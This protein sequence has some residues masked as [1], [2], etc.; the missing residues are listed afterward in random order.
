VSDTDCT[1]LL[2]W[3]L[4]QLELRWPGF[5]KVRRQV[6]KRLKQRM[7][8]LGLDSYAAY[9]AR[10]EA[11]PSEWRILDACCHITIS[12]F[13]RDR[14]I[15]EAV[16]RHVLPDIAARAKREGRDAQVWS[17]GC[18]SGEEPYTLKILW[19]VEI[20][21]EFPSVA[22][23]IVASDIDRAMLA[24]AREGRFEPTSLRELPPQLAE[25]AFDRV[26][27][28][29]CVRPKHREGIEF[30]DQDLRLEMPPRI[31]DLILCRYVAFT[32][33]AGPL[34]RKILMSMLARLRPQGYL[35]I[36]T[37]EH[38]PGE[39]PELAALDSAPQI[40]QKR[41]MLQEA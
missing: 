4:P 36:G 16:R 24:R 11:D 7:R 30:L 2:Q 15:F 13:F 33:F 31:F 32:Y 41:P 12:R 20:A 14:G 38:L 26:G 19:D 39:I 35:V 6:C 34:Q 3:A 28:L 10:L 37:H 21:H 9:R 40:F 22:F 18:A 17:A 29:Y 25:E 27:P 23:C 8:D 1:A 5:R